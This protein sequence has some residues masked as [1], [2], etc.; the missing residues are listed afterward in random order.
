L[1]F[2][3]NNLSVHI[4]VT[5]LHTLPGV[6]EKFANDLKESVKHLMTQDD[7]ELGEKV[8]ILFWF[9]FVL[10][11]SNVNKIFLKAKIYCSTQTVPDSSIISDI[12]YLY[13]D[14]CYS[15]KDKNP[16]TIQHE[17]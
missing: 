10:V 14:A 6:K 17:K 11:F 2:I 8:K 7:R 4:A 3:N 9:I 1:N 5:N 15:T 13:L 16:E 12:T